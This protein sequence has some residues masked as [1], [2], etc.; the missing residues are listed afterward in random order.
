M[1][2]SCKAHK[3]THPCFPRASGD[4]P[5]GWHTAVATS[6][7]PPRERGWSLGPGVQ[8]GVA[9]VSPARAG[10]VHRRSMCTW[11][12]RCFPRASGDGPAAIAGK[13]ASRWF[14]PRE[15][16]WSPADRSDNHRILV[17][18]ARAG[19]VPESRL[20]TV[21]SPG[22]PRASGDGPCSGTLIDVM[23]TFPPRERGW[24]LTHR[25]LRRPRTV[26]PARAGMVP[27]STPNTSTLTSFPRASGDGPTAAAMNDPSARFPPRERGW[28]L[29]GS[30]VDTRA[31]VSPARAGMVPCPSG[32]PPFRPGFPRASGDGPESEPRELR[33]KG[34]PPRE[35]GCRSAMH[36]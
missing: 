21:R 22:F 16:G 27:W 6:A 15:R 1:V 14:P 8:R 24:S 34:F 36:R 28:S 4:G 3:S 5:Q 2:P 32:E 23:R 13:P 17:S 33:Y 18:P 25:R 20:C 12:R 11:S 31:V 7:F 9:D 29:T 30:M 35:R 26:S 19:M 10:M